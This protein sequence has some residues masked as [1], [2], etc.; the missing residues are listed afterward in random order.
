MMNRGL[1]I[2]PKAPKAPKARRRLNNMSRKLIGMSVLLSAVV[3]AQEV[4]RAAMPALPAP[5]GVPKP[6]PVTDAP[7][8]P[9][10]IL[11]GGMVVPLY[12]PGSSFLKADRVREAEVYNMSQ[13]VAGRINSIVNIHNPSIEVHLVDKSLN[14]GAVVILAA[15]GGHNTL[16]VFTP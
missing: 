14:T 13:T 2:G 1:R 11:Q 8:A 5:L 4:P 7:Y 3:F 10:P 9:Q 12:P 16:I 6:G 15:G